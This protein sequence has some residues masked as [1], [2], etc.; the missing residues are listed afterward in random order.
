MQ[1]R[2]ISLTCIAH[3][4]KKKERFVSIHP[5]PCWFFVFV[6]LLGSV[7]ESGKTVSGKLLRKKRR[8]QNKRKKKK[9][10]KHQ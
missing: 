4:K 3:I 2:E 7:E 6:F 1:Q 5:V 10:E 8:K 9:R